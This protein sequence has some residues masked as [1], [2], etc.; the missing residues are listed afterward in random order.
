MLD[1]LQ[2]ANLIRKV[3]KKVYWNSKFV[4]LRSQIDE[5]DLIQMVFC[6]L[7][8]RDNYKKYSDDY[9]LVGFIYRVANGCAISYATKRCNIQE[10]TVLD[11]PMDD[12]DESKVLRDYLTSY[13]PTM[14]LNLDL[15]AR[16][17]KVSESLN[18]RKIE[19]MIIRYEDEDTPLSLRSLFNFFIDT[20]LTREEMRNHIINKKTRIPVTM[21]TFNKWWKKIVKTAETVL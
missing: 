4:R 11:Q 14:D 19:D 9:S 20:K 6:K 21:M 13:T 3:T 1:V 5:D 16:I 7:L 18:S 10:W 15:Q 2:E 17:K 8:Y 12:S